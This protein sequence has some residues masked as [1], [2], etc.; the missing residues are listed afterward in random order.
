MSYHVFF[1]HQSEA[2]TAATV[3]NWSDK[4]LSP[5]ALLAVLYAP[6]NENP[7]GGGRGSAGKG[8]GFDA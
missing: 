4:T 1:W 7:V 2:R 5:E 6:I 3:W 8:R